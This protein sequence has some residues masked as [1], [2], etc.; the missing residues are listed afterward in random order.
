[1][2]KDPFHQQKKLKSAPV[3]STVQQTPYQ[4]LY[5]LSENPFPVNAL[6]VASNDDPRRNG[7]IY[8]PEFRKDEEHT[9]FE[10]FVQSPIGDPPLELGFLI[11]DPQAGGRGNGKSTFLFRLM[12][13]INEQDWG[14]WPKNPDAPE[15][16][17]LGV[18]VLPEPRKQ[19]NFFEL[20][21]L[22]FET[23]YNRGLLK[24]IDG[25]LRA[26]ILLKRASP[27]QLSLLEAMTP[28]ERIE[29]L[30]SGKSFTVLLEMLGFSPED[31]RA[32]VEKSLEEIL[33]RGV[34]GDFLLRYLDEGA[35]L[36]ALWEAWERE[37]VVRSDYRWQRYGA[38]WLVNGLMAVLIAAGY[39]HFHLL[40]DEFE[41]IYQYQT[42]K[43]RDEFLDLFRQ[44]F[45]ERDSVA[46]KK[47]YISALL[48][49]H[50]SI[51]PYLRENWARTGLEQFA[52]L[53]SNRVGI[54]SITL[55]ASNSAK[56]NHLLVTYLDYFRLDKA[57]RGQLYP[58]ETGALDPAFKAA[59]F[60]PRDTLWYAANILQKAAREELPAPISESY[61]QSFIAES[62]K[63][64]RDE[65]DVTLPEAETN[66]R[67]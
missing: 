37:D 35:D 62:P 47:R 46:V 42:S 14:D 30:S 7:K 9:F 11:V 15:L 50:P 41:K 44:H 33:G 55:G 39:R 2:A 38:E 52:P 3:V 8:D 34:S 17:A 16:F 21:R 12:R 67:G 36:Q 54:P 29:K 27:I 18:H 60:Y 58:F 65:D 53:A 25:Y 1:M 22:V 63:P 32:E 19:K 4:R 6:F 45:L 56:L 59:R 31:F 26:S 24:V 28:D 51:V 64:P 57:H 40:L 61:V 48:T 43:K 20:V 66:L 23:L 13:R 10:K 49:L 5:G